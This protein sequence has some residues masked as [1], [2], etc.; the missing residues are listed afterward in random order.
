MAQPGL[1][2]LIRHVAGGGDADRVVRLC[3]KIGHDN[4]FGT[5][6][7]VETDLV[8]AV[9]R[10]ASP[11][12]L[13]GPEPRAWVRESARFVGRSLGIGTRRAEA[14]WEIAVIWGQLTERT[15][16][17]IAASIRD[18]LAGVAWVLSD[19]ADAGH[20]LAAATIYSDTPA[21]WPIGV[22]LGLADDP[23]ESVRRAALRAVRSR[24]D[25]ILRATGGRGDEADG[26]L[27]EIVAGAGGVRE[28]AV[29]EAIAEAVAVAGP[30]VIAR[31][32]SA[33]GGVLRD[34][35]HPAHMALRAAIRSSKTMS[36]E[37]LV[38]LLAIDA[39][40][41]AA[42]DALAS[43][44]EIGGTRMRG[45][46]AASHLMLAPRRTRRLARGGRGDRL[47]ADAATLAPIIES[48]PA[49]AA[50]WCASARAWTRTVGDA[51]RMCDAW[52]SAANPASRA[53]LA[54][55]LGRGEPLDDSV[56]EALGDL[57][58]DEDPHAARAAVFALPIASHD[59]AVGRWRS[60]AR[61][62]MPDTRAI[63]SQTLRRRDPFALI[64]NAD[65][66]VDAAAAREMLARDRD[67]FLAVLRGAI[68][69]GAERARVG[70]I[71]LCVRLDLA[72][73]CEIELLKAAA[74]AA[75][76]S[77]S[78]GSARVAASAVAALGRARTASARDALR[79]CLASADARVRAN[80]IEALDRIGDGAGAAS[81]VIGDDPQCAQ[82]PRVRANAARALARCVEPKLRTLGLEILDSM[83][84]DERPEHRV[85]GLWLAG[86]LG[87]VES[88]HRVAELAARDEAR[89]VR[90]HA[91]ATARRLLA[92]MRA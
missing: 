14:V 85:S 73:D 10:L 50:R 6:D 78:G 53:T 89:I 11:R 34:G 76:G 24:L 41:P 8:A 63:A 23:D 44:K 92:L 60:L 61:A 52:L 67:G 79:A 13:W 29:L 81:R 17:A 66:A 19:H 58:F 32:G 30:G 74:G 2:D 21:V 49:D 70:A 28:R 12:G 46:I 39:L 84:E 9:R 38:R 90:E 59:A 86:R 91:R 56:R 47:I 25:R 5:D 20:R 77:A 68:E 3:R 88:A 31:R 55:V 82:P 22:V 45:A 62:P 40:A 26:A 42:I 15:R 51:D 1:A 48:T 27:T 72:R 80:T 18:E 71:R 87:R 57:A 75:S 83:L 4:G 37:T 54:R 35:E 33:L 69:T 36:G 16:A 43:L 7:G 64:E 65:P